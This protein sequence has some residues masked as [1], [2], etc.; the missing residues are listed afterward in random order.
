[1]ANPFWKKKAD[2]ESNK[3]HSTKSPLYLKLG[4]QREHSS[5]Y[6]KDDVWIVSSSPDF[7]M[8]QDATLFAPF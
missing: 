4:R 8:R 1:M 7:T 6:A 3:F 5:Q 2:S